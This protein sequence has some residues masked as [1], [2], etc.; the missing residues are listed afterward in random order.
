MST[1]HYLAIVVLI[2]L[3]ATFAIQLSEKRGYRNWLI[4]NITFWPLFNK[5]LQC[6]FCLGFWIAVV[7]SL[8]LTFVTGFL[9][10]LAIPVFSTPITRYFLN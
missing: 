7:L 5:M 4:D 1:L 3:L 10:Y 9:P 2:A 8:I 6:D